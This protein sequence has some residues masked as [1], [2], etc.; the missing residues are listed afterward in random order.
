MQR[1][2]LKCGHINTAGTGEEL[3]ACPACDAIYT[4]VEAAMAAKRLN[5]AAAR[6]ATQEPIFIEEPRGKRA[7]EKYCSECAAIINAKAEICP[8]CGVRQMAAPSSSPLGHT[9]ANGK[10]KVVAGMLALFLG[11]IGAHKFYLGKGIQGVLYLVFCWMFIPA[12]IGFVEG[13]NYLLMSE[14][15]FFQ[16]YGS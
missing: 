5:A 10:N 2:C 8:K 9:S 16:R 15:T 4:R 13:L 3:E 11:G 6:P 12:I 14:K 7:D 1:N